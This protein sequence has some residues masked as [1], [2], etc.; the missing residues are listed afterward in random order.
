[1][2]RAE[3][4]IENHDDDI[5][6]GLL[7]SSS[8]DL[9]AH[10]METFSD[11]A[12]KSVISRKKPI[13]DLHIHT[14]ACPS[15]PQVVKEEDCLSDGQFCAFF[16]KNGDFIHNSLDTEDYMLDNASPLDSTELEMDFSGRQL[17]ISSLRE[18]CHH[19]AILEVMDN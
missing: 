8:L 16:P 1:M 17:L 10:A 19:Q 9:D 4:S 12:F 7:Y 18:R 15:C 5:K 11:L 6:I 14:F 13:L 3:L 2:M